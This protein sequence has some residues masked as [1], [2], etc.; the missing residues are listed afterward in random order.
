MTLEE[1]NDYIVRNAEAGVRC[2]CCDQMVKIYRRAFTAQ[3]ARELI[4]LVRAYRREPRY[5]HVRDDLNVRN[6]GEFAQMEHWGLIESAVNLDST[7]RRSGLWKPT[8]TG[9]MFVDG[10]V[11][12]IG[13]GFFYDGGLVRWDDDAIDIIE[14]L[15]SKFN[16]AE[17]MGTP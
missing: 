15:R 16:Y 1:A 9:C 10:Q 14:A 3:M 13:H 11:R 6:G 12:V 8:T 5:Y 7:K 4:L 17:L 2:P